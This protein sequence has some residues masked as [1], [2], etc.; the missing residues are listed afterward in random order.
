MASIV[1]VEQIQGLAAGSTPNTVTIP[2]GQKI[3]ASDV[4]AIKAPGAILQLISVEASGNYS[5]NTATGTYTDATGLVLNITPKFNN[6]KIFLTAKIDIASASG[7]RFGLRFTRDGT[8]IEAALGDADGSRTR[9]HTS[10]VGQ[11]SNAIDNGG[12]GMQFLDSPATTNQVTYKVQVTMEG[13]NQVVINRSITHA[14]SSS[15]Y[16]AL[17]TLT[18]MEVAQ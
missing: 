16:V 14:D 2:T 12:M 15:V 18:A 1:S 17:S 8:A 9:S 7:Q 10:G 6:S 3:V 13:N 4:G 5:F 11:G